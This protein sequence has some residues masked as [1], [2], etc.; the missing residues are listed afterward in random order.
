MKF[1]KRQAIGVSLG[2]LAFVAL[3][4]GLLSTSMLY[5]QAESARFESEKRFSEVRSIANFMLFDLYDELQLIPGNTRA[6]EKITKKSKQYLEQLSALKADNFDLQFESIQGYNRLANI[7]GNPFQYNLGLTGEASNIY[8]I[9]QDRLEVLQEARPDDPR[10]LR[11]LANLFYDKASINYTSDEDAKNTFLFIE[12]AQSYLSQL[13]E[14]ETLSIKD[15]RLRFSLISL[16]A[17]TE[18]HSDRGA[19]A[20]ET[21]K[22]FESEVIDFFKPIQ[23]IM[24]SK[25]KLLIITIFTPIL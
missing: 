6:L 13:S 14:V 25:D 17:S 7:T 3:V 18:L 11:E 15:E 24:R 12:R 2:G 23:T 8:D 5:K 10:I 20:V 22:A 4:G 16:R 1:V 19:E 21:F 9:T